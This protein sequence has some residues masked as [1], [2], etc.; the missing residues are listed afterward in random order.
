MKE[1]SSLLEKFDNMELEDGKELY[2]RTIIYQIVT[3]PKIESKE[4][5]RKEFIGN[6]LELGPPTHV[7]L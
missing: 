3:I 1:Q 2:M 6:K 7:T 5:P 4:D